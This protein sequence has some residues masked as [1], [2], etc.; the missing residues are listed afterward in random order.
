MAGADTAAGVPTLTI[1][2]AI[3][4]IT[5]RR[6]EVANR[7]ELADLDT[8]L[9]KVAEVNAD[10]RVRVLCLTSLGKHFCAGF[11]VGEVGKS[12]A[13]GA[14]GGARFEALANAIEQARPVTIAQ[15]QGGAYGGACDLALACDFRIGTPA[16]EMIV[17]ATQLGLHFYLGGLERFVTRLGLTNARRVLLAAERFDAQGMHRIGMLDRIVEPADAL[18]TEV[19]AFAQRLASLAPLAL[20][21]MKQH[22]NRIARGTLDVEAVA[23]DIAAAEASEDLREGARAWQEKR[24]PVFHGR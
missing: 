8:L 18:A 3:A 5:L 9:T 23:R 6:P 21:P 1:N 7:L 4:T 22:L 13:N 20:L 11:N 17:P 14:S 2:G 16:S 15:L 10:A 24:K 19:T 12:N